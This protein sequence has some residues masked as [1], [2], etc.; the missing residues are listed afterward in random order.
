M[1]RGQILDL[2]WN[3]LL[4][5][6]RRSSLTHAEL[7]NITGGIIGGGRSDRL[8]GGAALE[9]PETGADDSYDR[10]RLRRCWS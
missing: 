4:S 9:L 3:A 6:F 7:Y 10:V 8:P 5:D 1:P 2:H